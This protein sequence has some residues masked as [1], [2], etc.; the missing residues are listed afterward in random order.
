MTI[1][2]TERILSG[3]KQTIST[4]EKV[5]IDLR[6]AAGLTGSGDG[7]GGRTYFDNA[8]AAL[9]Y[10][11]PIRAVSRVVKYSGSSAMFVAKMPLSAPCFP[12]AS[13]NVTRSPDTLD[14]RPWKMF[15][16]P[17]RDVPLNAACRC[18]S[19]DDGEILALQVLV[20]GCDAGVDGDHVDGDLHAAG[21]AGAVELDRAFLLVEAA[22]VGDRKSVV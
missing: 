2:I 11:N 17:A 1:T 16:A 19:V 6:E 21:L 3:I 9:R 18:P 4:G 22:A 5:T 20:E 12:V 15:G 7:L 8:F 10:A 14:P 13:P